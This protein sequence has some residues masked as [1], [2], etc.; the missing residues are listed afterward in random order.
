[1]AGHQR[2][3]VETVLPQVAQALRECGAVVLEAPTGSGKTTRVPPFLYR[4]GL[5]GDGQLVLLQ[6]RRVAARACARAIADVLGSPLGELVGYQIRF[7]RRL[8]ARTKINVVTEGILTRRFVGDS[9]LEG[10]SCVVL[11][12]FHERS[13]HTDT[14]LAFLHELRLLRDDLKIVVMSA[15]LR[16]E[17]VAAYLGDCPV[18]RAEGRLFPLQTCYQP[19]PARHAFG[20]GVAEGLHCLFADKD[21]DGGHVL[22]FLPGVPEIE[23]VRRHLDQQVWPA[24]IL[25]LHGSLSSEEQDRALRGG[26]GRRIIL[27]TNVAE[28]SLTIDGVSAVIDAGYHKQMT[29]DAFRGLNRLEMKRISVASAVQRA[30]RA[31]RQRPGRVIRLWDETQQALLEP[32]ERAEIHRVDLCDHLLPILD[33]HGPDLAAF[34]FFE[35]PDQARLTESLALL[36]G[37]GVLDRQGRLTAKG[38]AM[39]DF[40]LHPRLAAMLWYAAENGGLAAALSLCALLPELPRDEGGSLADQVA[41]FQ[42][43]CYDERGRPPFPGART[44]QR[45]LRQL[46]RLAKR[47]W[48][49]AKTPEQTPSDWLALFLLQGF[50]DRLSRVTAPGAAVTAAGRG[51]Q[52]SDDR[53][54]PGTLFLALEKRDGK[55]G[56]RAGRIVVVPKALLELALTIDVREV[57]VYDDARQLVVGKRQRWIGDFL[58][59]EKEGVKVGP[60]AIAEALAE[61]A[62]NDFDRVFQPDKA[63]RRFLCRLQLAQRHLADVADWPD[64]GEAGLHAMLREACYGKR[65]L[66]ELRKLDWLTLLKNHTPWPA[67]QVLDRELPDRLRVP[68]GSEILVDYEAALGATGRPVLAARIQEMFGLEETPKLARGRLPVLCHLLAPSRRPVQITEDL[69]G[70]WRSGYAEVRKEL[71]A[72]YA[73]HYWPENPLEAQAIRGVRPRGDRPKKSS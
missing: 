33:F 46:E 68:S 17:A 22:V 42:A 14:L 47:T 28:T 4:E 9:L 2:L 40:P 71:R 39:T 63:A 52:L 5:L 73:K 25:C 31:G 1:M 21:D 32:E 29:F 48:P 12:E 35:A 15:T 66:A 23:R 67:R 70:F 36:Q 38:K 45:G 69:A 8:S 34:P 43:W 61:A 56:A 72:R 10:V 64:V 62:L 20:D 60:E 24:E 54:A 59:D 49:Q 6:P 37:L 11:D 3:P 55:G 26:A 50:P 27:A 65:S 13:I 18:V 53:L 51:L 58:V 41:A 57:A 7:E 44:A 30:G 19:L 16:G